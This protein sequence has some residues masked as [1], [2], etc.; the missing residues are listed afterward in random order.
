MIVVLL[1][2]GCKDDLQYGV[3][4]D[5]SEEIGL[6]VEFELEWPQELATRTD[7]D[8]YG[9]ER[10]SNGDMIHIIGTFNVEALQEDGKKER[11]IETRYGALSYDGTNWKAVGG[12]NIKWPSIATDGQFT[13]YYINGSNGVLTGNTK[14]ENFRLSELTPTT[15]PLIATSEDGIP[16]GSAVKLEFSHICAYLTLLDIEPQVSD[17]YW[18]VRNGVLKDENG[19]PTVF[20]NAFQI[21][22]VEEGTY[23]PELNFSFIQEPDDDLTENSIYIAGKIITVEPPESDP[24]AG[25]TI[26][27]MY[28]LEP[29]Y[30][31]TFQIVY[32]ASTTTTYNYLEY[33]YN[34]IP[35]ID[36]ETLTKPLLMANTP[37]TL[38]ITKS[39]GTTVVSPP[40]EGGW[41][42]NGSYYVLVDVEEFLKSVY[43]GNAYEEEGKPILEKTTNGTRLL[44]NVDFHNYSYSNFEDKG[45]YPD[46]P[47]NIEFDGDHHYIKNLAEPLF[48]FVSGKVMNIG[49]REI[50]ADIISEENADRNLDNSRNG[51][52]CHFNTGGLIK[53]VRVIDCIFNVGVK[54]YITTEDN[55][56]KETHNIGGV[57]GSNMGTID[58]VEFGGFM[59][60]TVTGY[61]ESPYNNN[62]N[63]NVL[64]GGVT[65]QNTGE[66]TI[67]DIRAINKNFTMNIVNSCVGVLGNYVCGGL[68]GQSSGNITQANL[69][70]ITINGTKSEGVVSN[71]GGMV[72]QLT[73]TENNNGAVTACNV[74]GS[75][76]AGITRPFR[77]I[78]T[79]SYTGG[80]AGVVWKIPVTNC[81][82]LVSVA[83]PEPTSTVADVVYGTGGAFGR[84]RNSDTFT[85]S[86][87]LI[88]GNSLSGPEEWKGDFVGIAPDSSEWSAWYLNFDSYGNTV[89]SFTGLDVGTNKPDGF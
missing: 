40:S 64:I 61:A 57:V 9:N 67:A 26:N 27:A 45:F 30:Y 47:D 88:Y 41:D 86:E 2:G 73:V 60:I 85:F 66:G 82:S 83:G 87:L 74:S 17:S 23:G 34:K 55:N 20:N 18:L 65:G 75:V 62:V 50:T 42:D 68:V 28:F 71:M 78:T 52:L 8:K 13:A 36:G 15:D 32:P 22:L 14:T 11:G 72:G 79:E 35:V 37:Y 21:S 1:L 3:L 10:F 7:L 43:N 6:Q 51:A 31:D 76:A 77:A 4:N 59:R 54:S 49:I 25:K 19:Q 80:I 38:D 56:N 39:P 84:I 58:G 33:D 5:P 16:Y 46:I 70:N 29:G 48:H 63:A 89:K 44:T 53:N 69:S 12:S 81:S 24:L